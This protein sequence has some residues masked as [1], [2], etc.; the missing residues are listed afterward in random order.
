MAC[1]RVH[2]SGRWGAVAAQGVV[3]AYLALAAPSPSAEEALSLRVSPRVAS[4]PAALSITV[5]VEPR[6]NNRVLL[7]EDDS[8]S[9]YRS[10]QIQL[11]GEHAAR[12]HV[13][14]FRGLPAGRHRISAVVRDFKGDRASVSATVMVTGADSE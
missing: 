14:F 2:P 5:T 4:A 9:Y 1:A 11:E 13:L 10:S 8:G 7:V 12:T 6:E 3:M